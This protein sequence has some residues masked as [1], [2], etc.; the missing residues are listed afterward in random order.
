MTNSNDRDHFAERF[1]HD[2]AHG[3]LKSANGVSKAT[4]TDYWITYPNGGR[5]RITKDAAVIQLV[6][7][8]DAKLDSRE[9][10]VTIEVSKLASEI[11]AENL[12]K[13]KAEAEKR[14][15]GL[16]AGDFV[17]FTA[18]AKR[19][20]RATLGMSTW[21]DEGV[22]RVTD[23]YAT[24]GIKIGRREGNDLWAADWLEKVP[25]PTK[26]KKGDRVTGRL[27]DSSRVHGTVNE[28]EVYNDDSVGYY[29]RMDNDPT[30]R[31]GRFFAESSLEP[32]LADWEK[33]LLK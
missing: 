20:F 3:I 17:R 23:P 19:T 25:A 9:V 31:R 22:Y 1:A 26:F 30:H 14:T 2:A 32:E 7:F 18:L 21:A 13:E 12:A 11:I 8:P 27:W 15:G 24:G 6:N 16:K 4:Y 33:E 29:V 10:T 28:I 5:N